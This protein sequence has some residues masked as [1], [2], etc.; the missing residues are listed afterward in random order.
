[1][2]RKR[3]L[4]L[5]LH[6]AFFS[7]YS[8]ASFDDRVGATSTGEIL[9]RLVIKQGIQISNLKDIEIN[10]DTSVT[11]DV[12]V[13]Q[14]FCIT[15]NTDG[16]YTITGFSDQGGSAPFSISSYSGDQ[17]DFKLYFQDNIA[18][19]VGDELIPNVPSPQYQMEQNGVDCNGQN[20]AELKLLIPS[21][22]INQ[23]KDQE[24]RGFLNLTVAIE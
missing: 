11:S 4:L 21:T 1:M 2:S 20:N 13:S 12:V 14:R 10:V 24:Y 18:N 16:L 8:Q 5:C 6:M 23:A 9:I 17:I 22:Q 15:S 19:A 3:L 7:C